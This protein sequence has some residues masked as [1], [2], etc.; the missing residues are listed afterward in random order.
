MQ[1]QSNYNIAVLVNNTNQINTLLDK[2]K[3]LPIT[4][5]PE[6]PWSVFFNQVLVANVA[7]IIYCLGDYTIVDPMTLHKII[8][9]YNRFYNEIG[10]IYSDDINTYQSFHLDNSINTPIA[11]NGKINVKIFN[12]R[13]TINIFNEAIHKIS[14]KSIIY[15]IPEQLVRL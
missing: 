13:S 10:A 12:E 1:R 9:N 4:K 5:S 14:Q 3:F 7:P 15:H 6:I 2:N 8:A 11:I